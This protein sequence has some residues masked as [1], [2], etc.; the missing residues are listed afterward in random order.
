MGLEEDPE[1]QPM[2]GKGNAHGKEAT[3]VQGG[4][5]TKKAK[6]G[7]GF[8]AMGT[9]VRD[10]HEVEVERVLGL[11]GDIEDDGVFTPSK[12]GPPRCVRMS[13]ANNTAIIT[14]KPVSDPESNSK[15]D[16]GQSERAVDEHDDDHDV[17]WQEKT[18]EKAM[19]IPETN[20]VRKRRGKVLDGKQQIFK[21]R[22]RLAP[23]RVR[24]HLRPAVP[25]FIRPDHPHHL[26]RP[27]VPTRPY[28]PLSHSLSRTL[29]CFYYPSLLGT[30][31]SP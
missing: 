16:G 10:A 26:V 6:E 29:V 23:V 2:N 8:T 7:D 18:L 15:H 9:S 5:E 30:L 3:A 27:A 31:N 17:P 21:W 4:R 28:L 14:T 22:L 13:L 1:L 24:A 11:A 12:V 19:P 20:K 25:T